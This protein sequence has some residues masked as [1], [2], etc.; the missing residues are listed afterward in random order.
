MATVSF[1]K[2][3]EIKSDE[4]ASAFLRAANEARDR[5]PIDRK[6]LLCDRESDLISLRKRYSH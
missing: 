6:N 3:L 1:T 2:R 5:D 4:S